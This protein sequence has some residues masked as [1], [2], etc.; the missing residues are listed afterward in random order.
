MNDRLTWICFHGCYDFAYMLKILMNEKLPAS[1]DHFEMY[2]KV[3]FPNLLDIK[4][5]R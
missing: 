2:L 1:R 5:F 4:S 3:F